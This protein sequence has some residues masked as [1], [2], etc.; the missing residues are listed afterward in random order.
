MPDSSWNAVNDPISGVVRTPPK[1]LMTAR[2]TG[3]QA[4]RRRR[5]RGVTR[6]STS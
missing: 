6:R 5:M 2:I 4:S 3:R 1:S